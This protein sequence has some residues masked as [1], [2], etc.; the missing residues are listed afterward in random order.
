VGLFDI[1]RRRA[2]RESALPPSASV[3]P[4][5]G[6]IGEAQPI[7]GQQVSGLGDSGLDLQRGLGNIGGLGG[8]FSLI[9]Q[10]AEHGNLQVSSNVEV[11]NLDPEG[12]NPQGA[13]L[14]D[15]I[16]EIMRRHGIDPASG[17]VESVDA[18]TMTEVRREV[19]EALS[20]RGVDVGD[21]S[22]IQIRSADD[23]TDDS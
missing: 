10:A 6:E 1:F 2:E 12:A 18:S 11:L 7:V 8:L 19:L 3:P 4:V 9:Q 20:R 15:E 23:A 21:S 13:A 16:S 5:G 14:H 22:S 17:A